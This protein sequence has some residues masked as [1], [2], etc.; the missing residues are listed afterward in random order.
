MSC[1]QSSPY[2]GYGVPF[3]SYGVDLVS[4][5][6]PFVPG[7]AAALNQSTDPYR[8]A[9]ILRAQLQDALA[10]GKSAKTIGELQARLSAAERQIALRSESERSS[11]DWSNL[12][13]IGLTVG[14]GIGV[15]ALVGGA[16]KL[17]RSK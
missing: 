2:A 8:Q 12:G 17:A 15:L 1:C 9:G 4:V 10:R 14:I 5:I 13:K 11:R 7:V 6:S 3:G 16:L